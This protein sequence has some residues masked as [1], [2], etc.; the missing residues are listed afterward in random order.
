MPFLLAL[1]LFLSKEFKTY[2]LKKDDHALT[3]YNQ[4]M[5]NTNRNIALEEFLVGMKLKD[6]VKI[7]ISN[8]IIEYTDI[9]ENYV[10]VL[11]I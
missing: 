1:L 9:Q 7:S 8:T 10:D 5:R 6:K 11:N 2:F 4:V 3:L